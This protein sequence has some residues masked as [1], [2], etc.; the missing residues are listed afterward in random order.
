MCLMEFP[1]LDRENP[2]GW[3]E[4]VENIFKA[5]QLPTEDWYAHVLQSAESDIVWVWNF[6]VEDPPI[7]EKNYEGFKSFWIEFLER[8]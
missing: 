8:L 5:H 3:F 7:A 6:I 1:I 2:R 4:K